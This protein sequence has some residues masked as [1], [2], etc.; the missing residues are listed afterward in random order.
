M[1]V[2]RNAAHSALSLAATMICLGEMSVR[3]VPLDR[4]P[5]RMP[6]PT[7]TLLVVPI[8]LGS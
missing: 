3:S 2:S 4:P 8:R 5:R 7:V 6:S 1:V